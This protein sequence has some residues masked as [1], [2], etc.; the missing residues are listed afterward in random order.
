MALFLSA[1][2]MGK[3]PQVYS[4]FT[5]SENLRLSSVSLALA[6]ASLTFS[7]DRPSTYIYVKLCDDPPV[8]YLFLELLNPLLQALV[9][10]SHSCEMTLVLSRASLCY[11]WMV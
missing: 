11:E 9:G 7:A 8:A 2:I 10:E 3:K 1:E 4:T 5:A 6:S